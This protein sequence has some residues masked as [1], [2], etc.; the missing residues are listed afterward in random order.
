MNRFEKWVFRSSSK[1]HEEL[2]PYVY[3]ALI[4]IALE[5]VKS[6]WDRA[7]T[8]WQS[9]SIIIAFASLVMGTLTRKIRR[10][11]TS[12][13]D[14]NRQ[15]REEVAERKSAEDRL[16]TQ[17]E[18][19]DIAA[20]AANDAIWDWDLVS[21][22]VWSNGAAQTYFGRNLQ[23]PV[24]SQSCMEKIHPEDVKRVQ[25]GIQRVLDQGQSFWS[26]EY[27]LR[28]HDGNYASVL[29]RAY[30]VRDDWGR[31]IRMIGAMN[32]VT[33]SKHAEAVIL[34]AKEA[35]EAATRAKSEF[36]A[37][38][39]HEIRTPLNGIIGM[40]QLALE[41]QLTAEQQEYLNAI[42]QSSQALL[43][44]I[45][46]VLDFSKI[47]A[48]KLEFNLTQFNLREAVEDAVRAVAF[49]AHGKGL[50]LACRIP[51]EIPQ[52]VMGDPS[53][54]RQIL[55]NLIGNAVKF[56][57]KG[58]VVVLVQC[59]KAAAGRA[60]LHF[61]VRDT[62]IGI[63][64]EKQAQIFEAF[65]QGDS[66]ISREH[67]GT[68][69]GLT[70]SAALVSMMNGEIWLQ[71]ELGRGSTFHFTIDVPIAEPH[72]L[73]EEQPA[74]LELEGL[75]VLVVDD[76]QT[77]R[78]I[79]REML[80]S[81][82]MSAECV[83]GGR[84]ALDKLKA[85][86]DSGTPFSLV[87]TDA[88]MPDVDGFELALRIKHNPEATG[89]AIL[90]LTSDMQRGD[91]A[92]CRE[93]G[94]SSYLV[95]PVRQSELFDS[96]VSAL[97]TAIISRSAP[98]P[99]TELPVQAAGGSLSILLAEDNSVNQKLAIKMLEKWGHRV[100][101]AINGAEAVAESAKEIFDVILMD[102]QMPVMD[103]LQ[104]TA[105]IRE[106]DKQTGRHTPIVAVTAHAMKGDR[107]RC[108]EAGMDAYLSK[109]MRAKELEDVLTRFSQR[110]DDHN[111]AINGQSEFSEDLLER[112]G[113]DIKLASELASTFLMEY[114]KQVTSLRSA[115]ENHSADKVAH[116]A[117][118][119]KGSL[120]VFGAD[121]ASKLVEQLENMGRAEQL[122]GGFAL[123]QEL[124]PKLRRLEQAL[125]S[126]AGSRP[127]VAP[128]VQ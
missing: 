119:L 87:L 90:M 52:R 88:H 58:E 11:G 47:E 82:Q 23:S 53:R 8:P 64:L 102:V 121:V 62:G 127:N 33:K 60:L 103:G 104:A 74:H 72:C 20:R 106:R 95:K 17:V 51:T 85:A 71:S 69:L 46:D 91:T 50:E 7:L 34:R 114:P 75:R 98:A 123:L 110:H 126:I 86:K 42:E 92:R 19:F 97:G 37:N 2:S 35:A 120:L 26:D 56:T 76:N 67:G 78:R 122:D 115:L 107:E 48:R 15:L 6:H 109:P 83:D 21:D 101:L 117:H 32:D 22:K 29:D 31:P 39:S 68:G 27:R 63:P 81:W 96:I 128:L 79:L 13:H 57:A 77:N 54:L 28:L 108:L 30:V 3:S 38:M 9:H 84:A 99:N 1:W 59:D 112:F 93:L 111:G 49:A 61:S 40:T 4:F 100:K 36:L 65:S 73:N 125:G 113:G 66:S 43:S 116:C 41:T 124:E 89:A 70:I 55:I 94:I 12:L 16:R 44:V 105:Q 5:V 45:N 10:L 25:D 118:S 14:A 24:S 18:R 80:S